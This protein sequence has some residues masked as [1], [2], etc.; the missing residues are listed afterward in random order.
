[1]AV[2]VLIDSAIQ[3]TGGYPGRW[4]SAESQL[5]GVT[6]PE[7]EVVIPLAHSTLVGEIPVRP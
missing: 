4:R 5:Q 1:L 7:I 2:A 3:R 6:G